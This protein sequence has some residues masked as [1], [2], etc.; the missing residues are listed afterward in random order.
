MQIRMG[1]QVSLAVLTEAFNSGFQDYRYGTTF[2]AAE[3]ANFLRV[4]GV[5]LLESTITERR[6]A[7]AAYIRR[8]STFFPWPPRAD[9]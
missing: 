5:A 6:P 3:M 9:R 1:D 8:T 4:S 2:T 7:Y